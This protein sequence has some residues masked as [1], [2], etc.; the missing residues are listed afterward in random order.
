[1]ELN[2]NSSMT[3]AGS[4]IGGRLSE[5]VNTVKCSWLCAKTSPETCRADWVQINQ[6][7]AFCWSSI[8]NSL[9]YSACHAHAPYCR[10]WPAPLYNIFPH[11]LINGT[12][13]GINLLNTK[14][15]FWFSICLSQIFLILRRNER[16]MIKKIYQSSC[17]V[18]VILVR[19][20][21]NLN[22]IDILSKNTQI[23]NFL[24][25]HPL[26][27]VLFHVD[28]QT[29]RRKRHRHRDRQTDRDRDRQRQR[30]RASSCFSKF[31]ENS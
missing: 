27:A 5:A 8:T 4:N 9:R 17:K 2:S 16:N 13:F 24:I 29:E 21:S 1:M 30:W 26:G 3:P 11:Y 19:F 15:A 10:L 22:L 28:R 18:P 20:Y 23:S 14:C 6:K 7:V 25:I 12:I 31:C